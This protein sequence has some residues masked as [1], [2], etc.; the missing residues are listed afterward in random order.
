MQQ[1]DWQRIAPEVAKQLLGNPSSTSSNEFRWGTKGSLTLNLESATWYDFENDVGGGII[2]LIKHLNQDVNTVL[3]QFGYDSALTSNDSL[4]TGFKAPQQKNEAKVNARSFSRDQMVD[5]YKQA[6]IKVKYANNFMVLRFPEGHFI[7]QKYA[8]FSLNMD[9]SWS[10]KRPEGVLPIY[11]ENKFKGKPVVLNEGEKALRGC[12]AISGDKFNSCTWHGGV[13]AWKKADWSPIFNKE[14]YIFPDND[15]AGDKCAMEL[16]EYLRENKCRVSVI[17]PPKSF[18]DKDDL[19]DAYESGYFKSSEGFEDYIKNNK[20]YIPND[21]VEFLDYKQMEANDTPPEWLIDTILEKGTVA[22]VY[23]EPKAGKSFVGIS[24][25]LSVATG[26]GWYDYKTKPAGV[27]YLCGEGNKSIFKRLLAWEKYFKTSI[28]EA[29]FKVSGKAVGILDDK[30][31]DKLLEKAHDA[32]NEL[33]GLGLIIID[34]IQRNFGSGDENSTSDM[35]QFIQRIDRLKFETGACVMLIHHTGHAG[36]KSNGTRRGRGSSVLPASVDSEFYIER[37]DRDKTTGII[38]LEEK[39]MYVKMSQTLNKEDMNMPIMHFRMDTIKNLGK[40]Q[41]KK[42]AVLVRVEEFELPEIFKTPTPSPQQTP[43]LEAFKNLPL[44]DK[45]DSPQDI[46][47]MPSDFVGRVQLNEKNLTNSQLTETF[48]GLKE[49]GLIHHIPNVG[50]Q[51]A[52]YAK[53]MPDYTEKSA[54]N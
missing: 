13:N 42:S 46:M 22:S 7:K 17:K 43:V 3:K 51:H 5:L 20:K 24:M 2:D 14:V 6:V 39:V 25:M 53:V 35:N 37:D 9:G 16:H 11:F 48:N 10:M 32:K 4:I 18:N 29:P 31:Y 54:E 44:K 34:T 1:V 45:P 41:D 12:E 52:D 15:E 19:Y 38:G 8:P 23:A 49:K 33:G 21:D 26:I 47:Y 27:L 36:S 28:K 40:N 50:Y 30:N